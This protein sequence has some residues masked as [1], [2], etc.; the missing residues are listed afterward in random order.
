M[1]TE[2][3]PT[4]FSITNTMSLTQHLRAVFQKQERQALSCRDD[5]E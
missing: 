5:S 1:Q 2:G 3:W 4:A